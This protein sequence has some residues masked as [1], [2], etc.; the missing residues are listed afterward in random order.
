MNTLSRLNAHKRFLCFG[1]HISV[2]YALNFGVVSKPYTTCMYY[3]YLSFSAYQC[4]FVKGDGAGGSEIYF[5]KTHTAGECVDI[6]ITYREEH[7]NY[8][9]VTI[10]LKGHC[11]CEKNMKRSKNIY[12]EWYTCLLHREDPDTGRDNLRYAFISPKYLV[13]LLY[14]HTLTCFQT[15]YYLDL[16][17]DCFLHMFCFI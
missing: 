4:T 15:I 5:G 17:T 13:H 8:N 10:S 7:P 11:Y 16:S 6:C 1:R 12:S 2:T 14:S 9:G 3:Q